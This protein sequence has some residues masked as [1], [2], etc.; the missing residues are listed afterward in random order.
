MQ[1]SSYYKYEYY[2]PLKCFD[3]LSMTARVG[4]SVK[5]TPFGEHIEDYGLVLSISG[6]S[7]KLVKLVSKYFV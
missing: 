7:N 6:N 5:R 4:Q 1:G 3:K 2:S